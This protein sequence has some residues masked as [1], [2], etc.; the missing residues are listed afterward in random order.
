M[1]QNPTSVLHQV[2]KNR[3]D[4]V[5]ACRFF[6][7]SKVEHSKIVQPLIDSTVKAAAGK[8]VMVVQD[9][10]EVNYEDHAGYLNENDTDLGPTGNNKDIGFFI[11][12]SIVIDL[13]NEMLLGAS[14]VF[15]WN[16]QYGKIDKT[17]RQYKELPITEKE[18]F[19][20]IES[21]QRSKQ[22]LKEAASILFV[23]DRESDIYEEF[24]SIPDEKSDVLIRSRKTRILYGSD[25]KLYEHLASQPLAGSISVNIRKA[26]NRQ[27]RQA[28]LNV[29]YDKV[30][31][32]KPRRKQG[33]NNTLP[34]Y[35]ELY[36]IEVKETASSVPAGEKP[37]CWVLLTT[38]P[39]NNLVEALD[40]IKCYALRWQIELVFA[41]LKSNGLNIEESQ[42]ETGKALKS[43]CV[44]SLIT[45]L[46]IN[47][48]RLAHNDKSMAPATI[49]FTPEQIIFLEV[50]LLRWEGKTQ[51]QKNPHPPQSLAW[52]VWIIARLGGWKGYSSESPPGNKTMYIGWNDFNRIYDGWE[53]AQNKP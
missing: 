15:I 30:N 6:K 5:A 3:S 50:L 28:T 2:N 48:L 39:V 45:A 19:R 10:S 33:Q 47:Q 41:T 52:A 11:H 26:K 32:L 24:I 49:V 38:K 17:D 36:A 9:T 46:R 16:R 35:V 14:D 27:A 40:L 23:S 22:V 34:K 18:S 42:L 53:L 1:Y 21:A 29:R 37:I 25:K 43:I 7:N 20:W 31:I 44:M 4:Y 8:D 51:K 12:P 13:E